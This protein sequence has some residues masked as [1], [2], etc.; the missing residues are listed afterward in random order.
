[1]SSCKVWQAADANVKRPPLHNA[2]PYSTSRSTPLHR[3][4]HFTV[5]RPSGALESGSSHAVEKDSAGL[6]VVAGMKRLHVRVSN[7]CPKRR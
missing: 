7:L 3:P 2:T 5:Y 4:L 6:S 1:M